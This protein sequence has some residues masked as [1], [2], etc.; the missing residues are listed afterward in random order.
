[1]ARP[2][3]DTVKE[4]YVAGDG[5]EECA[6]DDRGGRV[7]DDC[8]VGCEDAAHPRCGEGEHHADDRA[9]AEPPAAQGAQEWLHGTALAR[10]RREAGQ[11]LSGNREGIED[12]GG[13]APQGPH[14]LVGGQGLGGDRR[15]GAQG[16]E[17]SDAQRDRS[18]EERG[19]LGGRGEKSIRGGLEAHTLAA[20]RS[21]DDPAEKE[22]HE[23]LR[24]RRTQTRPGDPQPERVHKR[25]VRHR[26]EGRAHGGR[27]QR[28]T[29]V[30]EP[31]Q[32]TRGRQDDEHAD[33][34]RR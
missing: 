15:D 26:I 24:E 17:E 9:E 6:D 27:N 29:R 13:E 18:D 7:V 31:A 20:G 3:E 25:P 21:R 11:C 19:P 16:R 10:A 34:A 33:Q 14:D 23:R 22:R 4:E 1:M 8:Q 28:S 12:V 2:D 30:L 32:G 5:L